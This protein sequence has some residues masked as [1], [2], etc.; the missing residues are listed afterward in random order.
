MGDRYGKSDENEKVKYMDTINLY[1]QSMSQP[2]P[3]DKIEMWH[4]HP[5]LYMSWSEETLNNPDDTD[6]GYFVEV[7][8]RY[9]DNVTEKTKNFTFCPENKIIHKAKYK[10]YMKKMKLKNYTKTMKLI[11]DWTDKKK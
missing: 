6:I 1:G 3:Y 11:C 10:E 9:P 2:L 4:G 8:L 5:D 7:D